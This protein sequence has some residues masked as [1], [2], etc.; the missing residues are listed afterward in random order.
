MSKIKLPFS[1]SASWKFPFYL[2][3]GKAPPPSCSFPASNTMTMLP[4]WFA[5]PFGVQPQAHR[6]YQVH[7][8][9]KQ[10][11]PFNPFLAPLL[12]HPSSGWLTP[13]FPLW[14]C[15]I[16]FVV[17]LLAL[18]FV[19]INTVNWEK[20]NPSAI[21]WNFILTVLHYLSVS[22]V[23]LWKLLSFDVTPDSNQIQFHIY[24]CSISTVILRAC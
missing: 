4:S 7:S 9:Q 18:E 12:W 2:R 13:Y 15:I 8:S 11:V 17:F 21:Q 19:F 3:Q 1:D 14:V 5:Q 6:A 10:Q 20:K 22:Y 16:L 24:S 23:C